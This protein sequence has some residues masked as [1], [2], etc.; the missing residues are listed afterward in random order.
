MSVTMLAW[1]RHETEYEGFPGVF[2]GHVRPTTEKNIGVFEVYQDKGGIHKLLFRMKV[3][4]LPKK[5]VKAK[6]RKSWE[7][8]MSNLMDGAIELK[9]EK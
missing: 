5:N 9:S 6:T 3:R 2:E 1:Q 4:L 8:D 7:Q